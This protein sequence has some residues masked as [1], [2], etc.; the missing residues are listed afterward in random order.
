MDNL[1]NPTH[2]EEEKTNQFLTQD[3]VNLLKQGDKITWDE[4]IHHYRKQLREFISFKLFNFG[5]DR[6]YLDDIEAQTW[7]TVFQRIADFHFLVEAQF[8]AWLRSISLNH[9]HNL[10]RKERIN[11]TRSLDEFADDGEL[12]IFLG[13]SGLYESSVDAQSE[14]RERTIALDKALQGLSP[15]DREI[16]LRRLINKETPSDLA[17]E[18]NLNREALYKLIDRAKKQ[19]QLNMVMQGFFR[20]RS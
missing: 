17:A 4:L 8:S 20:K 5:L 14:L 10:R 6:V 12:D 3:F 11:S 9:I 7:L 16:L 2:S 19:I 1:N 18:Y 15:R 13:Q